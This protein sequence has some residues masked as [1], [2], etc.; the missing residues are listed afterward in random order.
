MALLLTGCEGGL[1]SDANDVE[2]QQM[3][4]SSYGSGNPG[5]TNPPLDSSVPKREPVPGEEPER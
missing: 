4:R 1:G 3:P 5:L 2:E